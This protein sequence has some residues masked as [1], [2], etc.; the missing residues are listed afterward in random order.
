MVTML[1]QPQSANTWQKGAASNLLIPP[2]QGNIRNILST[3]VFFLFL[4]K[5]RHDLYLHFTHA[6]AKQVGGET[7]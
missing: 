4:S 3:V 2:K 7:A 5:Q 1:S 6:S